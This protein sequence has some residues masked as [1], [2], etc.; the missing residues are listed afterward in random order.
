M[1]P[2]YNGQL[3]CDA[4]ILD[5]TF[6]YI[7]T[8][9]IPSELSRENFISSHVKRSPSLRLHN[10]SHLWA[11]D[12][13]F[14]WCLY[15]KQNITYSLMDMNLS[16]CVQLVR[17]WVD[18]SKIKFIST[19][20]HVISSIYDA[21]MQYAYSFFFCQCKFL[22]LPKLPLLS[23]QGGLVGSGPTPGAWKKSKTVYQ[24]FYC[25]LWSWNSKLS[26]D[27]KDLSSVTIWKNTTVSPL[28]RYVGW[29][30]SI[31]WL[32][33]TFSPLCFSV[34]W[35][36]KRLGTL[37]FPI[38]QTQF[39]VDPFIALGSSKPLHKVIYMCSVPLFQVTTGKVYH[40]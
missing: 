18:H 32:H 1:Q 22:L 36:L 35:A 2:R 10:K 33:W 17:Y 4:A 27:V 24:K 37:C 20:G 39:P 3:N 14:H 8:S 23:S 16:S 15:N 34:G 7:N 5:I 30:Y 38:Q 26:R 25:N 13:V 6:Y 28:V 11:S 12:L 31:H 40:L 9:E 19:Q 29:H 21:S